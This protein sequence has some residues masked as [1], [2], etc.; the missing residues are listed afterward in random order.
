MTMQCTMAYKVVPLEDFSKEFGSTIGQL[1]K[2]II[3]SSTELA[4]TELSSVSIGGQVV[5][6]SD[7]FFAEAYQLLL[8][9][10]SPRL[11]YLTP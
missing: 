3:P 11:C 10:V 9:E 1:S 4:F 6:V 8:V 7:E 2:I 5:H